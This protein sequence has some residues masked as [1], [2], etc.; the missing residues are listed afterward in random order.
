MGVVEK[1]AVN[2]TS[3]IHIQHHYH[4]LCQLAHAKWTEEESFTPEEVGHVSHVST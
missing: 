3:F 4:L 1:G 2:S